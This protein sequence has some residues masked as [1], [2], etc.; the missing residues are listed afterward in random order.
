MAIDISNLSQEKQ[1]LLNANPD[2][3]K[4]LEQ[5]ISTQ[6]ARV[7]RRE[8][9]KSKWQQKLNSLEEIRRSHD[10]ILKGIEEKYLRKT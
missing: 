2:L 5:S 8:K 1:A 3:L 10:P 7:Q 9:A 6:V 4:G